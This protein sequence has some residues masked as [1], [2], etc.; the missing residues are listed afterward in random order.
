M[1]HIWGRRPKARIPGLVAGPA[2]RFA[3][4]EPGQAQLAVSQPRQQPDV[5]AFSK[6]TEP[7]VDIPQSM[8]PSCNHWRMAII[9]LLALLTAP[10]WVAETRA[11]TSDSV[12][13]WLAMVE[14]TQSAQPRWITPLATVTP[15]LEQEVR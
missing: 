11:S 1:G 12:S 7:V 6:L 5:P 4:V 10:C 14:R 3:A 15:R 9:A 2:P 13:S 8:L